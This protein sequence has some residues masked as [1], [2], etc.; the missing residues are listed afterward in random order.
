MSQ[1]LFNLAKEFVSGGLSAE[2]FVEAFADGWR[3]ERDSG[4]LGQDDDAI[5]EKLS[6]IFCLVDLYN[7]DED[8]EEYEYD[9]TRLKTEIEKLVQ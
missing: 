2:A 4:L 6:T 3:A 1:T 9:T 5:S 7:P 8:R